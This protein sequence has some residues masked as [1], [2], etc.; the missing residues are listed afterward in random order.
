MH[1][2]RLIAALALGLALGACGPAEADSNNTGDG[3]HVLNPDGGAN[4]NVND[5]TNGNTAWQ[6]PTN[7][8]IYVNTQDT[9][10]YVDPGVSDQ[11]VTIGDFFGP[12]TSDSGFYDI[13]VNEAKQILGI[14]AEGLY[15]VD[16]DTAE[17]T[18][19]FQFPLNSP[20]FFSLSFV[21]GVDPAEPSLDKLIA[22]SVEEGEWVLINYPGD[23]I[24]EIFISLGYYDVPDLE[25]LSSGDIISIQVDWTE[26]VTYATLK[27]PNYDD[28]GCESD[29]LA[30]IDAENGD[31]RLIGATG[32]QK[33]F[34][35]GY[36]G[37]RVYGFTG[38]GDYITINV[39]TGAGTLVYS[40][41]TRS[42]WGAG[43]TTIPHIVN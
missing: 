25:W 9:L 32:F 18:A 29:W 42:Y 23:I 14:S 30:E 39:D 10:Y 7:S 17:C 35:L 40:D 36:W 21:K 38:D 8:R 24:S 6:P 37:D 41:A 20:H 33:I 22:A 34:G 26:Y 43:N 19:V 28:T 4:N 5:N 27:C 12:C 13:A 15:E 2:V 31:A 11:L 16:K 3:G 1:Y